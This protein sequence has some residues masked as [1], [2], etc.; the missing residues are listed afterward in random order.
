MRTNSGKRQAKK[1][2]KGGKKV[3]LFE[4]K[5]KRFVLKDGWE[6]TERVSGTGIV[7]VLAL[8]R[9]RK[10]ILVE[11]FR[12][13]VGRQVIEFPAGWA[14]DLGTASKESLEAAAQRELLEETGYEAERMV[15]LFQG[16]A[17]SASS[18]DVM[19]VFRAEG[20][21]KVHAGGG[22]HTESI[23]VHEVDLDSMDRWLAGKE[24]EGVLVDPR[25]YAGLYWLKYR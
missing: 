20:L 25:I 7:A 22:D 21:R 19:V 1:T 9:D 15:P 13:P 12:I 3:T 14:G 16:P 18:V 4:G 6:Y 24:K 17:A 8:T 23:I 10:V 2:G 5:Y 11:Q